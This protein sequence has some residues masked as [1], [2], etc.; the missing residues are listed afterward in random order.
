[1]Y[2]HKIITSFVRPEMPN[3]WAYYF[4]FLFSWKAVSN[5]ML[6]ITILCYF[7]AIP[8]MKLQNTVECVI[9]IVRSVQV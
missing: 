4:T 8:E 7:R 1:M 6:Q 9:N 2:N 3:A 5:T